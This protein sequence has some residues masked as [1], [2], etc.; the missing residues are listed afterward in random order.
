[1]TGAQRGRRAFSLVETLV[2]AAIVALLAAL[3][4]PV[5]AQAKRSAN[6]TTC[7]S[8]LRQTG[9]ALGLYQADANGLL[10]VGT[11]HRWQNS[12]GEGRLFPP[13]ATRDVIE[14]L[15]RYAGGSGVLHCPI[16]V[17]EGR[18]VPRWVV[19]VGEPRETRLMLPDPS[20]VLIE[21]M[22]HLERGWSGGGNTETILSIE[23]RR[24]SHLTLRAD[25][26]VGKEDSQS[27]HGLVL[28][29][30]G[31]VETWKASPGGGFGFDHGVF[32][33]EKWPPEWL[34]L[35]EDVGLNWG[36]TH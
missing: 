20:N 35:P 6:R 10:P 12:D 32:A 3:L 16:G 17:D 9:V 21:C 19:S 28:E 15:E 25:L 31:G 5:F 18:Y 34:A 2:V 24:G 13:D 22:H 7:L 14:P 26:S 23:G 36:R 33:S 27:L 1:M 8:N 29:T 30:H 4:F 11:I